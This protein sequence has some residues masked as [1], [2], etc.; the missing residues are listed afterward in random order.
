MSNKIFID[1][2]YF[3]MY[4]QIIEQSHSQRDIQSI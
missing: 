4:G 2:L 3:N 1:H